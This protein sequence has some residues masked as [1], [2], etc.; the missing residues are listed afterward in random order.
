MKVI[1]ALLLSACFVWTSAGAQ[2]RPVADLIVTHAKVWTVDET[3]PR[4]EA[5][6]V[7]RDRIIAVGTNVEIA[8]LR[9]PG[10]KVIDAGGRLLLPGFNDA[11]VHFVSGGLQLDSVQLDDVTSKDEVVRRIAQQ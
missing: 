11:H 6:A 8:S 9:G 2:S 3:H 5:V 4:A 10:T 1:R 7:F